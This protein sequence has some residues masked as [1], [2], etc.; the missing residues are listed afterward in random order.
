[1]KKLSIILTTFALFSCVANPSAQAPQPTRPESGTERYL[2]LKAAGF[3]E[4]CRKLGKKQELDGA[5][6]ISKGECIV[7]SEHLTKEGEK[8][9]S[10]I[11]CE[12][13]E[14]R[15]A[16]VGGVIKKI[17]KELI[18]REI[19]AECTHFKKE[20]EYHECSKKIFELRTGL[21]VMD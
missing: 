12:I 14:M 19:T 17:N 1:M 13:Q 15:A 6:R 5:Y 8:C 2:R 4:T 7:I 9:I 18:A 3:Y 10:D 21:K 11:Q 16:R 20:K